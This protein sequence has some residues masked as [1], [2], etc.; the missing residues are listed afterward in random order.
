MLLCYPIWK[1]NCLTVWEFFLLLLKNQKWALTNLICM[2][3]INFCFSCIIQRKSRPLNIVTRG[4]TYPVKKCVKFW[5]F[6]NKIHQNNICT[7][8]ASIIY[9]FES[10]LWVELKYA[11]CFF[12]GQFWIWN[13]K[14]LVIQIFVVK[15][16]IWNDIN[17]NIISWL[18]YAI[19]VIYVR[20]VKPQ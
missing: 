3:R 19:C 14:P 6:K 7:H 9:R 10:I 12:I 17:C 20:R 1:Q 5:K 18:W 4:C 11:F 13:R 2:I 15:I 8:Y 16:V